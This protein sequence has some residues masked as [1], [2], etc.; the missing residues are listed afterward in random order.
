MPSPPETVQSPPGK[1]SGSIVRAKRHK[2][3]KWSLV[4]RLTAR[5]GLSGGRALHAGREVN[6]SARQTGSL[7]KGCHS[8][9]AGCRCRVCKARRK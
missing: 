8:H 2:S 9:R 3:G 7:P 1:V 6:L 5:A 4:V